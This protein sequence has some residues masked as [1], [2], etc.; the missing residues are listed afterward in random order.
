MTRF[1][2]LEQ[3]QQQQLQYLMISMLS[4]FVKQYNIYL[5]CCEVITYLF[6]DEGVTLSFEFV[7]V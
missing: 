4:F 3:Q 5:P 7:C 1:L 6:S 2:L